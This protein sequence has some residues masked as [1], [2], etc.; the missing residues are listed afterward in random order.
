MGNRR[1]THVQAPA[2]VVGVISLMTWQ[3]AIFSSELTEG[4]FLARVIDAR[5]VL[6]SRISGVAHAVSNV[7]P[8]NGFLLSEG[9]SRAG[10]ITCPGH[11]WRFDLITGQKQGDSSTHLSVYPT[12]ENDG[13]IEVELPEVVAA[14]SLREI[15]LASARG[16]DVNK[17]VA[18]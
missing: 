15:L 10:C 14:K 17:D 1:R 16:E 13:W 4:N 5:Q 18:R 6:L 11:F 9:V 12:L 3:R 7:C 8:H 2:G